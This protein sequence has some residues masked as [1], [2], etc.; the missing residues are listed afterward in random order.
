M[1]EENIDKL[2]EGFMDLNWCG[3]RVLYAFLPQLDIQILK[4]AFNQVIHQAITLNDD[5][6]YSMKTFLENEQVWIESIFSEEI[7]LSKSYLAL[8]GICD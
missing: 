5:W 1:I 2:L 3:S 4:L 8:K 7:H 6:V